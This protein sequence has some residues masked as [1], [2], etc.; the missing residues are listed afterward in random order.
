MLLATALAL[1]EFK[2]AFPFSFILPSSKLSFATKGGIKE[3]RLA[4]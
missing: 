4:A 1:K 3:G 2:M